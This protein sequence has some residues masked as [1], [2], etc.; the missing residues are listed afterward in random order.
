MVS[1]VN[2]GVVSLA[3]SFLTNTKTALEKILEFFRF[4]TVFIWWAWTQFF[5]AFSILTP[6]GLFRTV[7]IFVKLN[8]DQVHELLV[9]DL[10]YTFYFNTLLF[11]VLT[12][13]KKKLK[14]L[15][16]ITFLNLAYYYRR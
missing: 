4:R 1:L 16:Q 5:R 2:Q 8:S 11:F 13:N 7:P 14:D 15:L 6:I 12:F 3:D 10:I 9:L